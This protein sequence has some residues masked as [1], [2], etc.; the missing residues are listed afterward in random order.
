MKNSL[1]STSL[2]SCLH[3]AFIAEGTITPSTICSI[4]WVI[5]HLPSCW[6]LHPQLPPE[7]WICRTHRYWKFYTSRNK[8]KYLQG[9]RNT[10]QYKWQAWGNPGFAYKIRSS[11]YM[12]LHTNS[13]RLVFQLRSR[14]K[15]K[16]SA[17][18]CH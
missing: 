9:R 18:F 17:P 7:R 5:S 6:Q 2:C 1:S 12:A 13:P 4:L 11:V 8:H 3:S 16:W 10:P 14:G 15:F